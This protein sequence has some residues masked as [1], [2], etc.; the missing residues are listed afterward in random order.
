MQY[1]APE[2]YDYGKK[3]PRTCVW[4]LGAMLFSICDNGEPLFFGR[5]NQIK[6]AMN[7]NCQFRRIDMLDD[8]S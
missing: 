8:R 5:P 6:Q 2:V 7:A 1:M 3:S 4:P